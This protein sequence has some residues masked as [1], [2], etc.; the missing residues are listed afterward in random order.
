LI[1]C[2][3][4]IIKGVIVGVVFLERVQKS[5]LPRS[6]EKMD[7]GYFA[8]IGYIL[9][10]HSH[11]NPVLCVFFYLL[12]KHAKATTR[13]LNVSLNNMFHKE[14]DEYSL[15][16][17]TFGEEKCSTAPQ[18]RSRWRIIRNRWNLAYTL[19]NNPSLAEFRK[20]NLSKDDEEGT[21][22][23]VK[24][25]EDEVLPSKRKL[26]GLEETTPAVSV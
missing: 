19:V 10:E 7:P 21:C 22:C 12:R 15:N 9:T 26:S 16:D 24:E 14:V 11:A 17:F 3:L 23:E 2:L 13:A 25:A 5:I 4:R 18:K 20:Q 6:F 8:Y 1:S